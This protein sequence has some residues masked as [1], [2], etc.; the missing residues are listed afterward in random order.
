MKVTEHIHT[1]MSSKRKN[2][3]ISSRTLKKNFTLVA[4]TLISLLRKAK[5]IGVSNVM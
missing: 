4:P 5:M 2:F 1:G 3:F